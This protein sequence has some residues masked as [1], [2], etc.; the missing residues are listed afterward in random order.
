M[1]G[2]TFPIGFTLDGGRYTIT[3]R[4]AG[5]PER[6]L[7]RGVETG[8][9][10][11]VLVTVGLAQR[12]PATIAQQLAFEGIPRIAARRELMPIRA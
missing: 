9:T 7:Y 3:E 5:I 10:A 12:D 8:T 6:G 11:C 1:T 2:D 4:L